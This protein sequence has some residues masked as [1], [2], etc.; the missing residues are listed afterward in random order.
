M[1][2][3]V[4]AALLAGVMASPAMAQEASPFSGFRVEGLVGYDRIGSGEVDDGTD[5]SDNEGDESLEGVGYGLGVGFDFDLGGVVAG[6]EGEYM[7]SSAEAENDESVDGFSARIGVGRDLYVGGRIGFAASPNA[8]IYAKA[9]YTNTGVEAAFDDDVDL[10]EF[11]REIDG[12]R[13][14]V[15]GE[16][17]FGT[18]A[19]GKVEYRYSNYGDLEFDD[20]D[21]ER[22]IDVDRHQVVAGVGFR[23]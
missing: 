10:F 22:N 8:L 4:L 23:F 21:F 15:G 19:Y 7:E 12:W 14:G 18:N 11:E 16:F 20:T 13:A 3:Y 1:R 9:G 17:R 5:T 6:I 2:K